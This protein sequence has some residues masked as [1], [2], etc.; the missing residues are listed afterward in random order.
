MTL[1]EPSSSSPAAIHLAQISH[2]LAMMLLFDSGSWMDAKSQSSMVT[3]T[4]YI[5]SQYSL[6]GNW[7]VLEKIGPTLGREEKEW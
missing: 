3:T 6:T 7:S 1:Y 2:L 5:R 4:S